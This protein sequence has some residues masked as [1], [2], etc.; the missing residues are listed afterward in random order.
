MTAM[1]CPPST[2]IY[3]DAEVLPNLWHCSLVVH[4]HISLM[5]RG[6]N[7]SPNLVNR[8]IERDPRGHLPRLYFSDEVD[9]LLIVT[10][11]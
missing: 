3:S 8:Y 7:G 5:K 1:T 10:Q 11:L 9:R 4:S 6:F 2:K